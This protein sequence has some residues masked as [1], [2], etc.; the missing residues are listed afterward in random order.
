MVVH[1]LQNRE[2]MGRVVVAAFKSKTTPP[3]EKE[4]EQ[5]LSGSDVLMALQRATAKKLAQKHTKKQKSNGV[6][7][8]KKSN[9]TALCIKPEW[10]D[11]L[12]ELERR[13]HQL[14][15]A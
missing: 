8:E 1:N 5:Q 3:P 6:A 7:T 9:S 14:S 4:E 13:L 11:R 10:S 12:Q 2:E 15:H